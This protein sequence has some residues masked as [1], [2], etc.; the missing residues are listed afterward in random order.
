MLDQFTGDH[1]TFAVGVGSDD[2]FTGFAEQ[3]FHRLELAGGF[4]FDQHLPLLRHDGQVFQYP[5][6]IAGIVG[7]GWCGFQQ[8]TDA[9]GYAEVVADPA[10]ITAPVGAEDFGDV[11]GLG[12]FFAEKEAHGR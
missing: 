1:F 2:Q 8:V 5:A 3:A 7:V 12:G 11:L 9:P 6:F 4:R 10:A